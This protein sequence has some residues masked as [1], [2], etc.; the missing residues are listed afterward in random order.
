VAVLRNDSQQLENLA[1][2]RGLEP[3]ER[4]GWSRTKVCRLLPLARLA[5]AIQAEV[6]TLTTTV[7]GEPLD[8][9]TLQWIADPRDPAAQR[10]RFDALART[11][12]HA[13]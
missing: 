8:R 12:E 6:A 2:P 13:A 7:P 3:P 4:H 1:R 10:E 9:E 11:W 5:P